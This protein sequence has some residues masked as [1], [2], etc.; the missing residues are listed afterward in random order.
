[1]P[2]SDQP[3]TFTEPERYRLL[4]EAI[5]DYAIY[6]LDPAGFIT[7][8]NPGAQRFKGYAAQEIIGQHFSRFY[9]VADRAAELPAR[10]LE[11]ARTKG[12]FEAEGWRVRK[13]GSRFWAYVVIDPIRDRQG[14]LL[15]FAKVTRDLSERKAAEEALRQSDEQFRLLVQGVTDYA[16]F[17]L[18]PQG[19]ITNWNIGAQRIKGYLPDEIV[20]SH[21]SRFYTEEDL[22]AGEPAKALQAAT[23]EGRFEKEGWRVRKDGSRFWAH[24]VIDAIRSEEGDLVGFAKITRDVTER[25][26]SREQLDQIREIAFQ[27]Q[28]MDAIGQLTGG[29]AHDFNNLLMAVLSSLEL[30]RK[31]VPND[32]K[33]LRLLENAVQG[34]QRGATLTKRLL[35]FARRQE[36]HQEAV[37]IPDMV[38]GMTDLLGRSL[39]SSVEIETRFPLVSRPV[40][41]DANQLEM[42]LLNLVVNARDAMPDGGRVIISTREATVSKGDSGVLKPGPYICLAVSDNGS[43]MDVETLRR[44]TEPF[45]TTKGVGKGTGLGLS[46]VHG[47]AEQLGG[48][49]TLKSRPGEGTTAELWLPVAT[50]RAPA[51]EIDIAPRTPNKYREPLTI[52]VVDDDSLVLTN[53]VAMIED[54]GHNA[55]P[56]NSGAEALALLRQDDRADLV[57][58][59]QVM[60]QMS[61]LQLADAIK[62][63]WPDLPVIIATGYADLPPGGGI[64]FPKLSKPYTQAQLADWVVG[65]APR[66]HRLRRVLHFRG[67]A[68]GRIDR[69]M[70][71]RRTSL[72]CIDP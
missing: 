5:T 39:G 60:P 17:L 71:G 44:A 54:L 53:T 33:I 11:Q 18:D 45:F 56:V 41:A 22:K 15:G 34:T 67:G 19:R 49:F 12:Q 43:G 8:W 3:Q 7:S 1:M 29:I 55:L 72:T 36:L 68:G 62:A 50:G 57:V 48:T 16:I 31:R 38:R 32:P 26:K 23:S 20:G 52:L 58:T 25:K 66:K 63:E 24:V 51:E 64:D 30:I 70:D 10:A 21:F 14:N 46:M 59:D 2:I 37:A 4:I 27:S 35:A 13:D 61:G 9:T 65:Y 40:W 6:M 69:R 28:K 42:V 47:L